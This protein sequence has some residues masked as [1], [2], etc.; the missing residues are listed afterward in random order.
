MLQVSRIR[1]LENELDESRKSENVLSMR[2]LDLEKLKEN[3]KIASEAKHKREMTEVKRVLSISIPTV[4][5]TPL[6]DAGGILEHSPLLN[7]PHNLS[8]EI[9]VKEKEVMILCLLIAS[10]CILAEK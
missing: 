2:Y 7:I 6:P 10:A 9:T 3:D 5:T 8:N 4:I 1:K